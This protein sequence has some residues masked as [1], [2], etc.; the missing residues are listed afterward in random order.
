MNL[1][2]KDIPNLDF[3]NCDTRQIFWVYQIYIGSK[4]PNLV[5]QEK[6]NNYIKRERKVKK[7]FTIIKFSIIEKNKDDEINYWLNQL[8]PRNFKIIL[9]SKFKYFCTLN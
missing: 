8:I 4:I 6:I 2:V 5:I 9:D 7:Y 1:V 3:N